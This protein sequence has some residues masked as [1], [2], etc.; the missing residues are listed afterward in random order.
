MSWS[1]HDARRRSLRVRRRFSPIRGVGAAA[2]WAL[3]YAGCETVPGLTV[4]YGDSIAEELAIARLQARVM[5]DLRSIGGYREEV[6]H[7]R[8]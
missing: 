4:I 1:P 6:P 8:P 7:G 3:A 5:A 2:W